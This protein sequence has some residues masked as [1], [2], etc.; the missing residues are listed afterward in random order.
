MPNYPLIVGALVMLGLGTAQIIVDTANI[1]RAFIRLD[2]QQRIFFMSDVTEPIFAAKHA[3]YFTQMLVGDS[4]VVSAS[5]HLENNVKKMAN[6]F[7]C[8]YTER[9]LSGIV[10]IG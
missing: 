1:F 5:N 2:R 6:S 3:I 10:T 7:V 8:R 4:I 9:L